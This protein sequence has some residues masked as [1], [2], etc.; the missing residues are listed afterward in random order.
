M[1]PDSNIN[2]ATRSDTLGTVIGDFE[3]GDDSKAKSGV[4]LSVRSQVYRRIGLGDGRV[5]LL[6]RVSSTADTYRRSEYNDMAVEI[7]AGPEL[8]LGRDQLN[9]ELGAGQ[10]WFGQKPFQRS[11]RASVSY[12]H[13]FGGRTLARIAAS[14]AK[15]DNRVNDLQDGRALFRGAER[16]AGLEPNLWSGGE[17]LRR[18]ARA[19]RSRLFHHIVAD[20]P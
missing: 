5:S 2:R 7:A 3:I 12:S 14:A 6:G 10:R 1:A 13:P 9:F 18:S 16:R 11:A 15:I 19:Q 20:R 4:G 17:R 8:R